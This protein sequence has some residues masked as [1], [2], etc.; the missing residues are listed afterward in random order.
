[1]LCPLPVFFLLVGVVGLGPTA[2]VT[3]AAAGS[4]K[5]LSPSRNPCK[6]YEVIDAAENADD[7]KTKPFPGPK[8]ANARNAA[9]SGLTR[10][11]LAEAVRGCPEIP[12][13]M[14]RVILSLLQGLR[15]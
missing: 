2:P 12:E 15:K 11:Q 6:P 13:P 8:C 1:M 9:L 5:P 7:V 10:E 3:G 4:G 14:R